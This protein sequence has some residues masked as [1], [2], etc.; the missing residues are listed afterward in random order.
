MGLPRLGQEP[1]GEIPGC[2][3]HAWECTPGAAPALPL[4]IGRDVSDTSGR[5]GTSCRLTTFTARRSPMRKTFASLVAVM[6]L[7]PFLAHAQDGRVSLDNVAKAM[8]VANVK[9]IEITGN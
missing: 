7:W 4:D 8:G 2:E 1:G 5:S 6:L 3:R 9:S